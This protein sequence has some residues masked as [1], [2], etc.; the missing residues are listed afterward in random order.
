MKSGLVN[1]RPTILAWICLAFGLALGFVAV[2][3]LLTEEVW[4]TIRAGDPGAGHN[5]FSTRTEHPVTYWIFVSI[6]LSIA[7]ACIATA[8]EFFKLAKR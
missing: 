3:G 4:T 7:F 1:F 6:W 5:G 8:R 2:N